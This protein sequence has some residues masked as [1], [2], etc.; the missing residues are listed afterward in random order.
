M[1]EKTYHCYICK[2]RKTAQFFSK[3]KTRRIGVASACKKCKGIRQ[4]LRLKK[5]RGRV[6]E[7]RP[8]NILSEDKLRYMREYLRRWRKN[9]INR[10]KNRMSSETWLVVRRR[11]KKITLKD[12][13]GYTIEE[14][15]SHLE[16][17]F[18]DKMTLENYGSYWVIDHIKP[19]SLFKYKSAEDEEFKKCWNLENLQPLEK[20]ANVMKGNKYHD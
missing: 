13:V 2:E 3:E 15:V 14:L 12:I 11:D 9:P 16:S 6:V 19:K 5:A 10:I 20:M 4:Y 7:D 18:D 17:K 1:K 8:K